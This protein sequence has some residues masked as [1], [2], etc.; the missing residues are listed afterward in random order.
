LNDEFK[1]LRST[2]HPS[3]I[4]SSKFIY[5]NSAQTDVAATIARVRAQQAAEAKSKTTVPVLAER[6]RAK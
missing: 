1:P 5:R 3:S 6:R 2:A 4:L